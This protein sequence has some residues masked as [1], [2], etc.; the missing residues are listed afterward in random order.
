M[1]ILLLLLRTH[2]FEVEAEAVKADFV[3]QA[4][5]ITTELGE[6]QKGL[7]NIS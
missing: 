4:T 3:A 6:A 7:Y 1:L 2:V 5:N